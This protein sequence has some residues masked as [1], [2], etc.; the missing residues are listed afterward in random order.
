M[1]EKYVFFNVVVLQIIF[2]Q[3]LYDYFHRYIYYTPKNQRYFS[4]HNINLFCY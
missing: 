1:N 4:E 2:L 3:C